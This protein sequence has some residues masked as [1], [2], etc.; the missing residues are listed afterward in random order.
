VL[1]GF[2]VGVVTLPHLASESEY[3]VTSMQSFQGLPIAV[4]GQPTVTQPGCSPSGTLVT[5]TGILLGLLIDVAIALT[6]D[7][8]RPN[9]T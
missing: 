9:S 4:L 3:Q 2:S 6:V 5:A 1:V 8:L 7:P